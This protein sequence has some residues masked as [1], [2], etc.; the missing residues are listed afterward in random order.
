M[1]TAHE[2]HFDVIAKDTIATRTQPKSNSYGER[3]QQKE[4]GFKYCK[5]IPSGRPEPSISGSLKITV[6]SHIMSQ[7]ELG[8]TLR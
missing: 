8:L 6:P 3:S 2:A 5:Q 1:S 7:M 4:R